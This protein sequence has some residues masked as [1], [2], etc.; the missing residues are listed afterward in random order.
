M[1]IYHLSMQIISRSKGQSAVASASYRSGEKL[2]DERSQESKYYKREVQPETM[3]L[4]PSNSPSWVQNREFLW[5]EVERTEKRKDS[6]L[7]REINIALPKELSNEQQ[8]EL[9]KGYVQDQFVDK[10]MVADIAIHRDDKENPHAHIMLTMRTI[11]EHGFGK[12]N[13]EWNADFANAKENN[14]GFVKS[15]ENCLSVR[16]QWSEYANKAL[17]KANIQE[18]IT[19]QSHAD[20]GL[21]ILPTVHLGHVASDMEKKGIETDRGNINREVKQ[22]NAIIYDFQKYHEEKQQLQALLKEQEQKKAIAFTTGEQK[23]LDYIQ[24]HITK[25]EPTLENISK[26]KEFNKKWHNQNNSEYYQLQNKQKNMDNLFQ[27]NA[28]L[29]SLEK[30]ISEKEQALEN[31]GFFQR[32]QKEQLRNEINSLS[33]TLDIQKERVSIL[34]RDN[35]IST[36]EEIPFRKKQMDK[37]VEQ[38][39]TELEGKRTTYK[40][41]NKL[42]EQGESLLKNHEIK[43]ATSLYP[44]LENKR[45]DYKTAIKLQDIHERYNLS[46][47]SDIPTVIEKNKAEIDSM[48]KAISNYEKREETVNA[49]EIKLKRITQIDRQLKATENNPYQ[50]GRVLNDPVA[51]EQYEALNERKKSIGRELVQ[52]GYKNASS[53]QQDRELINEQKPIKEKYVKKIEELQKE[54]QVLSDVQK[55]LQRTNRREQYLS[56]DNGLER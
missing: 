26:I 22:H 56:R 41:I 9:I 40:N 45:I 49:A 47:T 54:N 32:K 46:K 19:H 12:K 15:S 51:K 29:S 34:M 43:K 39:R 20:R 7:A 10:G 23:V 3:I 4:A 24:T 21:E 55:D 37:E 50:Y 25:E 53:I 38:S 8:T 5:N 6:Q 28:T 17:E 27:A 30:Q 33:Q 2:Y 31:T 16:E 13:R 18:R 35:G 52:A 48:S 42:L 14:R 44:E 11:D 36:R 1:A